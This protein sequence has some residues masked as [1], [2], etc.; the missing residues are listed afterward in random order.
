MS[1]NPESM[2]DEKVVA[3]YAAGTRELDSLT[4]TQINLAY[5]QG[6]SEVQSET[7]IE[8]QPDVIEPVEPVEPTKVEGISDEVAPKN[9][10]EQIRDLQNALNTSNQKLDSRDKKLERLMSDETY[11]NQELGVTPDYTPSADTDLLADEYLQKVAIT[12]NKLK[13]LEARFDAQNEELEHSKATR[14][15]DTEMDQLFR[16]VDNLQNKFTSLKTKDNFRDFDTQYISLQG[17]IGAENITK[18]MTDATYKQK[19]DSERGTPGLEVA[20]MSKGLKIYEAVSKFREDKKLNVNTTFEHTFRGTK[21]FE[22]AVEA[23]FNGHQVANDEALNNR[24]NEINSE[25]QVLNT[26]SSG[27]GES[28]INTL[29]LELDA[30]AKLESLNT[31]QNKRLQEIGSILMG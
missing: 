10:H 28:D 8:K 16:D 11:R 9:V 25:P 21:H 3:E 30:L 13:A 5:T 22:D 19:I 24:I 27:V 12:E 20:D 14:A 31:D 2:T 4:D 1:V 15:H 29:E 18:Y 7:V 17:H 23:K 6:T 26:V